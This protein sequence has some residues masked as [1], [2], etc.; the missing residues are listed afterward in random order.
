MA[1]HE[2]AFT[3]G[4]YDSGGGW[5]DTSPGLQFLFGAG[6][7]A[8]FTRDGP[9][10]KL[11]SNAVLTLT[12]SSGAGGAGTLTVKCL[13]RVYAAA[14][15]NSNLP[16][17]TNLP[18]ETLYSASATINLANPTL[19]ISLPMNDSTTGM[20]TYFGGFLLGE[21]LSARIVGLI[22]EWSGGNLVLTPALTATYSK[23]LTGLVSARP[24]M[25]RADECPRCGTESFRETW[26]VDGETNTLVCPECYDPPSPPR[27]PRIRL[28]EVNP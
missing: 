23:D 21:S 8:R 28:N 6:G 11:W 10:R 5:V 14:W 25:S 27:G 3:Q 20:S 17:N 18:T 1:T 19:A 7:A 12:Y 4:G 2:F 16:T 15:T 26:L 9:A 24:A 22:F 13:K